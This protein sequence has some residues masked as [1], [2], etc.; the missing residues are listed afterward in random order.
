M[1]RKTD[2]DCAIDAPT[3]SRPRSL[4]RFRYVSLSCMQHYEIEIWGV[5]EYEE[6]SSRWKEELK[7]DM[8]N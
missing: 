7:E 3:G 4:G 2:I 5:F 8:A 1:S 6:G